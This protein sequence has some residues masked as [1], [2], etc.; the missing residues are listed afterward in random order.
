MPTYDYKCRECGHQFELFQYMNDEPV[1][2]CPECSGP[3][4]RIIG[5]GAGLIFKGNGFYITD[6]R[7]ESYKKAAKKE[8]GKS[9]SGKSTSE[10]G[11]SSGK[12][13]S[14]TSATAK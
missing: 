7:S 13:T 3:V 5:G 10:K 6:Y 1:K 8:S 4:E 11:G 2:E 12:K 9:D 14:D